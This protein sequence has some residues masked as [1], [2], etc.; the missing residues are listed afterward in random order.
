VNV[1]SPGRLQVN[2]FLVQ[3]APYGKLVSTVAAFGLPWSFAAR[4]M[5]ELLSARQAKCSFPNVFEAIA[6][7][8]RRFES[9]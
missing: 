9:P 2:E 6:I 4:R 7:K 3:T 5:A 1:F 8:V